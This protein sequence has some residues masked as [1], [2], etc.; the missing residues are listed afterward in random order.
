MKRAHWTAMA[1]TLLILGI[2]WIPS[3]RLP[4]PESPDS[5]IWKLKVPHAD[6]IIHFGVFAIYT[7]LWFR[8]NPSPRFRR[9]VVIFGLLLAVISEIGQSHPW[10]RRDPDILDIAADVAGVLIVASCWS[11]VPKRW[12]GPSGTDPA[13]AH[14]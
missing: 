7:I 3:N 9:S 12:R 8:T 5:S 10:V 1:W 11:L 2:C 6:K 13:L 14:L 4:I